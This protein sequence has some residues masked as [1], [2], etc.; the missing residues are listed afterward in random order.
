VKL[1]L[2]GT[3]KFMPKRIGQFKII[4]QM[5]PV[6]CRLQFPPNLRIHDVFHVSLFKNSLRDG[7]RPTQPPP[8]PFWVDEEEYFKV[9]HIVSHP[10]SKSLALSTRF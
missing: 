4:E 9:E 1:R 3:P 7:R 2:P 8:F 6:A 5:N 10:L